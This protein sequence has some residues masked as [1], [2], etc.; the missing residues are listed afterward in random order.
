ML[1][2]TID[3]LN[4]SR[5]LCVPQCPRCSFPMNVHFAQEPISEPAADRRVVSVFGHCARCMHL[6]HITTQEV[7]L[8]QAP[9][10]RQPESGTDSAAGGIARR[11]AAC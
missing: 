1:T 6:E 3:A 2:I 7:I 11:S 9:E 4:V 10:S 8:E 5:P